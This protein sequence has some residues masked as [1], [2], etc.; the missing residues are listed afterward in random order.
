MEALLVAKGDR[1]LWAKY[2]EGLPSQDFSDNQLLEMAVKCL[3][4]CYEQNKAEMAKMV[5]K[6]FLGPNFNDSDELTLFVDL[7]RA[8][9]FPPELAK[10]LSSIYDFKPA[11]LLDN[12]IEVQDSDEMYWV[13]EVLSKIYPIQSAETYI[14]LYDHALAAGNRTLADYLHQKIVETNITAGIPGYMVPGPKDLV[15]PEPI[16]FVFQVPTD[17]RAALL[18]I[19]SSLDD[20]GL[21]IEK[22]ADDEQLLDRLLE[23][24]KK[25]PQGAKEAQVRKCATSKLG[26]DLLRESRVSKVLWST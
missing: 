10:Y 26:H 19:N 3:T 22:D 7:I 12:L 1:E 5:L 16:P 6:S 18:M 2:L 14:E 25:L 13:A 20:H 9:S 4:P 11:V 15:I 17:E 24:Y 21:T 23:E 8:K